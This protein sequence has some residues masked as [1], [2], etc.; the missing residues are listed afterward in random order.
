LVARIHRL[1]GCELFCHSF[2]DVDVVVH[3]VDASVCLGAD[4]GD[5][6]F[7]IVVRVD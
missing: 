1:R 3:V 7:F 6:F 5:F 2:W 4:W